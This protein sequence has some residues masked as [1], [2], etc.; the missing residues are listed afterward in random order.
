MSANIFIEDK[1]IKE[2]NATFNIQIKD[3]KV[4]AKK[5]NEKSNLDLSINTFSQLA[6]SYIDI[7]EAIILNNIN[8]NEKNKEA[9]DL[10]EVL[11]IK[12]ENYI[13]QYV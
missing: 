10:L 5:T 9:I 2:N 7:K 6:F 8:K 1:F 13:N 4:I 3:K 12:K 11:F